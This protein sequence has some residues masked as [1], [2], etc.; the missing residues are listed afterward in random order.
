MIDL[1]INLLVSLADLARGS[2]IFSLILFLP[3]LVA[4]G[5]KH[6]ID[7]RKHGIS[8]LKSVFITLLIVCFL[9]VFTLNSYFILTASLE[10]EAMPISPSLL[11]IVTFSA[12]YLLKII[13]ISV[14]LAITFFPIAFV[15]DY[16]HGKVNEKLGADKKKVSLAR[17]MASLFIGLWLSLFLLTALTLLFFRDG[18]GAILYFIF[19]GF[20]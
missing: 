7:K 10:A 13:L 9:G 5:I 17:S 14:T 6:G 20:G 19:F 8:W 12:F 15:G 16:I 2:F 1:I 11:E 4:L 18:F 3:V